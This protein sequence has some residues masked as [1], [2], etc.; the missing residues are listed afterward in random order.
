MNTTTW[1]GNAPYVMVKGIVWHEFHGQPVDK[2]QTAIKLFV[3]LQKHGT[4]ETMRSM[5][6]QWQQDEYLHLAVLDYFSM[7]EPVYN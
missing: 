5:R 4:F 3:Y 6:E 2:L 7:F 1:A